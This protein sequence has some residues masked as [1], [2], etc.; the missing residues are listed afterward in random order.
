LT[1]FIFENAND[2]NKVGNNWA[3]YLKEA[4]T[5]LLSLSSSILDFTRND[6]QFGVKNVFYGLEAFSH[7]ARFQS[8]LFNSIQE[9]LFELVL[10]VG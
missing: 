2:L 1:T 6:I 9:G 7:R 10:N 3:K 4:S 5:E 8:I